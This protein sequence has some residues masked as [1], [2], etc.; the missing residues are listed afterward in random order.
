[1]ANTER[2]EITVILSDKEYI[3]RPTFEALCDLED[4]TK[5]PITQIMQQLFQGELSIKVL[6][7]I[8]WAG[9]R[10]SM[11]DKS[12]TL[13]EVGNMMVEDGIFKVINQGGGNGATETN[14]IAL[15]ISKAIGADEVGTQQG[16]RGK[17][18]VSA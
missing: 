7:I 6:A 5:K 1:M 8:V 16:K 11:G 15:F 14:A 9:I 3:L 2:G 18:Q 12:P 13:D 10:G 17:K 4:R